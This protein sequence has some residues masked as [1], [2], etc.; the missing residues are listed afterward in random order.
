MRDYYVELIVP[1]VIAVTVEA[2]DKDEA[3]KK[4]ISAEWKYLHEDAWATHDADEIEVVECYPVK[5][6]E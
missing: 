4:A 2:Q 3:I 6:E 5:E 1:T